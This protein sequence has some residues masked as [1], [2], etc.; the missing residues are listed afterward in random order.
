[1]TALT[2]FAL[3]WGS[4]SYAEVYNLHSEPY[5][6]REAFCFT[7]GSHNLI[8]GKYNL[9]HFNLLFVP[10]CVSWGSH[11]GYVYEELFFGT[12]LHCACLLYPWNISNLMTLFSFFTIL[13]IENEYGY[14]ENFYKEDGKKYALW[15]AKMAVSQNTG[16][17][18]IM[19]QQWDA[20]DPVVRL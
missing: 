15:A 20:P 8:S 3:S 9:K 5:E 6:T 18:W 19:C 11:Y 13:Q 12:L 17:P 4:V 1:M 7:R 2:L 16:V 14:Y 10:L